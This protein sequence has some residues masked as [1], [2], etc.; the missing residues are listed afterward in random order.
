MKN[1]VI[2]SLVVLFISCAGNKNM[3]PSETAKIVAKSFF[4]KDETVLKKHTTPEGYD[5]FMMGI[6]MLPDF[7]KDIKVT[8]LDEAIIDE[9]T[10]IKYKTSYDGKTGIFKLVKENNQWKVTNKGTRE[11]GPF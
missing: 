1:L 9:T 6:N 5:S 8:I 3:T 2:C 4:T 10:W 7:D 11:K